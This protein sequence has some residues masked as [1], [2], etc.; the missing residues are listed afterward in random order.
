MISSSSSLSIRCTSDS[1][2]DCSLDSLWSFSSICA[3]VR[4]YLASWSIARWL[5]ASSF[6]YIT[7]ALM[8]CAFYSSALR[9][10]S[11]LSRV[12]ALSCFDSMAVSRTL[13]LAECFA[14]AT[15]CFYCSLIYLFIWVRILTSACYFAALACFYW[16]TSTFLWRWLTIWFALFLVSS[17]FLTTYHR[18]LLIQNFG[19]AYLAFFHF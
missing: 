3:R 19:S 14:S 7:I 17:I 1:Y 8:V 11:S 18:N 2:Y 10:I 4:F 12:A 15:T 16:W 13:L 6:C 9:C 5:R